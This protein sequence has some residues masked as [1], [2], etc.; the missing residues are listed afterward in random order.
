MRKNDIINETVTMA[1][2]IRDFAGID[3]KCRR[4]DHCP[5]NG[6]EAHDGFSFSRRLYQCFVCGAKGNVI[7]FVMSF[8][9]CDYKA[10][11]AE[12]N[13]KY[14]LWPDDG[15]DGLN[16]KELLAI[17]RQAEHRRQ[18]RR[19]LDA[20]EAERLAATDELNRLDANKAK[21]APKKPRDPLDPRYI[22]ACMRLPTQE[23]IVGTMGGHHGSS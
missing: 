3:S 8:L 13:K 23:Y 14:R 12:I 16:E 20:A 9:H 17:Q 21:F 15:V 1:D 19:K 10:A 6:C 22:E 18:E 11:I 7:G 5:I 2:I 4:L